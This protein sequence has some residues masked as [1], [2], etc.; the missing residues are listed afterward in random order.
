MTLEKTRARND[1]LRTTFH[2]GRVLMTLAVWSLPAQLRGQALYHMSQYQ[3]FHHDSDHSE[4]VF[5]WEGYVFH[6]FVAAF[7]GDLSI[8]LSLEGE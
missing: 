5:M 8:T 4:G 3:C 1:A 7:A 2:G 6:W